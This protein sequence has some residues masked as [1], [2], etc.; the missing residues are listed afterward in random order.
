MR[1][2]FIERRDKLLRIAIKDN[3][4]LS[5]CFIEEEAEEAFP[6]QIYKGIVKNVVPAI[7]CAFVDI[8]LG[9]NAYLYMDSRFGNTKIKKGDE[10]L[11]E[12]L[13]EETVGKGAK[14]TSSI[15]IAGR[16]AV[17]N[18]LDREISFSGKIK[19]EEFKERLISSIKK[20]EDVGIM[21][22]TNACD[23][24]FEN[25]ESEIHKLYDIY[26]RVK[27]EGRY[28]IKPGLLYSDEGVLDRVLRDIVDKNTRRVVV[29]NEE[30]YGH[31]VGFLKDKEE[32]SAKPELYRGH[33]TLF[34]YNGIEKELL[35]LRNN[36]V[37]LRCGGSIVIDKTEAMYVIDVNSGKNVGGVALHK[38]VETT[39]LQAAE[40]LAAQVRLRNLSGII[41]VDFIDLEDDNVKK[42]ILQTLEKGFASDKN[43][44]V[45]YP[46][47]ELNLVQIAR[48]RRGKS[49][50]EFM[51]EDCRDCRGKGRKLKISY[52][53][54]L[55]R[56]E[57]LKADAESCIK[58]I[59]IE[60]N[61]LYREAVSGDILEFIK[62]VGA[63]EKNIY[64]NFTD[65]VEYYKV[66]PLIFSSQIK[67][68]ERFK[69]YG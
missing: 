37:N 55:I 65:R 25:I 45:I 8:G 34:D 38:T 58:D 62:A 26:K 40:E 12:V 47:T 23:T 41:V 44:T 51:E 19:D 4:K 53:N 33:R 68:V 59:Y 39:N 17:I 13:K 5:E 6:G 35:S 49:I 46:F 10:L 3:N 30:D 63:L 43:K 29:D 28:R 50:Y 36:K 20:P 48:R 9:K 52:I 64:L 15:S 1:E 24:G 54:L 69:I 7:K 18:T 56:N 57:I 22:R 31:I 14:V 21:I 16:Y 42:K 27:E 2:L 60:I 66:E 11:L 61:E 32:L 67:N